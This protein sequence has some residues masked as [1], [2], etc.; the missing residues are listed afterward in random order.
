VGSADR[1]PL[2]DTIHNGICRGFVK[3]S[4]SVCGALRGPTFSVGRPS[5]KTRRSRMTGNPEPIET[6]SRRTEEERGSGYRGRADDLR[7]WLIGTGTKTLYIEPGSPWENDYC[8][9]F[10]W[11]RH[12][13]LALALME[14][15]SPSSLLGKNH[16]SVKPA[17]R[18]LSPNFPK[19]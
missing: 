3:G 12:T 10:H 4:R 19:V 1:W 15:P 14:A 8:E 7:Q 6:A 17:S 16:L 11:F 13:N 9:S 18:N 2:A 5:I